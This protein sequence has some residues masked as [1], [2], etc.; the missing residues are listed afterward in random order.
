MAQIVSHRRLYERLGAD[1]MGVGYKA[2]DRRLSR[3]VALTFLPGD[4]LHRVCRSS[5]LLA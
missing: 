5:P 3:M 1:G 2:E 4:G